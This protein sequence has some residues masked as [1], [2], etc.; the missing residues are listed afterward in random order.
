MV[1]EEKEMAGE[2][3]LEMVGYE[4]EVGYEEGGLEH[5]SLSAPPEAPLRACRLP[6]P[7]DD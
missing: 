4:E 2:E 6:A 7:I 1:G 3:E 5:F